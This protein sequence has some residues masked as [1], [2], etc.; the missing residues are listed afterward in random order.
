MG[1]SFRKTLRYR[2]AYTFQIRHHVIIPEAQ[3]FEP[4]TVQIA[5]AA[6]VFFAFVMLPAIDFDDDSHLKTGEIGNVGTDGMLAPE[7]MTVLLALLQNLPESPLGECHVPTQLA[8]PVAFWR[9][10]AFALLAN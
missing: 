9:H 8:R 10:C 4:D 2:G 3:Y 7:T 5:V 6:P 1:A